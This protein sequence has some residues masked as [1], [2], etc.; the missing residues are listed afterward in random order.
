M[1]ATFTAHFVICLACAGASFFAWS[2][3]VPQVIWDN[4]I[5]RWFGVSSAVF[6]L[7]AAIQ[8]GWQAWRVGETAVDASFGHYLDELCPSVAMVGTIVGLSMVFGAGGDTV[9]MIQ[10]AKTAFYC[11]GCGMVA[12]IIV[13]TMTYSLERGIKS[14]AP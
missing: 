9:A 11:T 8:I 6:V 13:R 1:R 12:M 3:G 10:H 5:A 7:A 2:K 4:E 14:A